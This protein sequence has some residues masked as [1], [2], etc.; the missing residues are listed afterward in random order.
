MENLNVQTAAAAPASNNL[1]IYG[2]GDPIV[3]DGS[4]YVLTGLDCHDLRCGVPEYRSR[5]I[6]G[7]VCGESVLFERRCVLRG[8]VLSGEGTETLAARRKRLGKAVAPD[9]NF[10]F[11][12][13][14]YSAA[15]YAVSMPEY[16]GAEQYGPHTG[17][18]A[19][20]L[21]FTMPYPAMKG[22]EIYRRWAGITDRETVEVGGDIPVGFAIRAYISG[23]ET[24]VT[25]TV[26]DDS[27]HSRSIKVTYPLQRDDELTFTVAESWKA[28]TLVRDSE[29]TSLLGVTECDK[30]PQLVPGV[31]KISFSDQSATV[32]LNAYPAYLNIEELL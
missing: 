8:V 28:V 14:D 15:A 2:G 9:H 5:G 29:S 32:Y 19:F 6:T 30:F 26:E 3:F 11:K 4:A 18:A 23:P 17:A 1:T 12:I 21:E 22:E 10:T 13:G 27:G 24:D 20:R 25:L 7:I 31:N 16:D